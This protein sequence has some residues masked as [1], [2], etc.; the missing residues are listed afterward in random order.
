MHVSTAFLILSMPLAS[1]AQATPTPTP[2]TYH[3]YFPVQTEEEVVRARAPTA[4]PQDEA[5]RLNHL[6][7]TVQQ[8]KSII[9]STPKVGK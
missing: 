2:T 9:N 6:Q 1:C 5:T 7:T 3:E 8:F 4:V